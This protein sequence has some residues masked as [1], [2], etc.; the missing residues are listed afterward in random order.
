MEDNST[1]FDIV[2]YIGYFLVVVAVIAAVVLPLVK[3]AGNP[4]SLITIGAGLLGLIVIFLISYALASNEVLDFYTR[5]EINASGSK[6][7]GGTIITM[8][9]LIIIALISI[10]FT[11]VSK[12]FR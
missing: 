4:K 8:Y 2:L 3:A 1:I 11:E 10:A 7:I 5:L 6:I 9:I 12:L